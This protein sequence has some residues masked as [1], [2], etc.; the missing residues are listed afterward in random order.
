MKKRNVSVVP[1]PVGKGLL[2]YSDQRKE[3]YKESHALDDE[4]EDV[5]PYITL[6]L[7]IP[8]FLLSIFMKAFPAYEF[9]EV[10]SGL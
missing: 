2:K 10:D 3:K 1:S 8:S 5:I 6:L 7:I 4:D 9:L